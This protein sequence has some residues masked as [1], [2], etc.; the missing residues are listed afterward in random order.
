MSLAKTF[1]Y[2]VK[3]RL[4][5]LRLSRL[6]AFRA[7]NRY[8]WIFLRLQDEYLTVTAD[9]VGG[10]LKP[11][12]VAL[13]VGANRGIVARA[14][15]RAVGE[16]GSVHAFEPNTQ[17]A[18]G[19]RQIKGLT[20]HTIALG[21]AHA[22]VDL[23]IPSK[24]DTISSLSYD[25]VVSSATDEELRQ[26]ATE[27]VEV[28]TLDSVDIEPVHLIKIDAQGAELDVLIGG[29]RTIRRWNPIILVEIWPDGLRQFG[30]TEE[31]LMAFLR[32]MRYATVRFGGGPTW[33]DILAIP[34]GTTP[35]SS[36]R[37][38]RAKQRRGHGHI[39]RPKRSPGRH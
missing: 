36:Q 20:V 38:K 6:R 34:I 11:G 19:L 30:A 28:R 37:P 29:E 14:M 35:K 2:S 31:S 13:D 25:A 7:L 16:S 39:D 18:D 21:R 9:I 1:F 10:L 26:V 27:A 3:R 17:L 33:W 22:H 24:N 23:Y 5:P 8:V 4:A 32:K 12:E 15:L